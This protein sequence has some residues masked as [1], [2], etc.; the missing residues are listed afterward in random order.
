MSEKT[1][2]AIAETVTVQGAKPRTRLGKIS[3][4]IQERVRNLFY[5][6]K[7]EVSTIPEVTTGS[8]LYYG[9]TIPKEKAEEFEQFR[10]ETKNMT[11]PIRFEESIACIDGVYTLSCP[12]SVDLSGTD[13]TRLPQNMRVNGNLTIDKCNKLVALPEGLWVACNL[14]ARNCPAL[15]NIPDEITVEQRFDLDGTLLGLDIE[16]YKKLHRLWFKENRID[17]VFGLPVLMELM[18]PD[19]TQDEFFDAVLKK[20]ISAMDYL[21]RNFLEFSELPNILPHAEKTFVRRA[22][23]LKYVRQIFESNVGGFFMAQ[24]RDHFDVAPDEISD[25]LIGHAAFVTLVCI[26]QLKAESQ[27]VYDE[28]VNIGKFKDGVAQVKAANRSQRVL[29]QSVLPAH[30]RAAY[31]ARIKVSPEAAALFIEGVR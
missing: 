11:V 21:C 4:M 16:T 20:D 24:L 3:E 27:S 1:R 31:M 22:P 8:V 28:A 2:E 12:R 15:K 9:H 5:Q 25:E 14:S 26:D 29:L 17:F 7:V 13:I 23:N 10:R 30:V 18:G 19:P 6:K